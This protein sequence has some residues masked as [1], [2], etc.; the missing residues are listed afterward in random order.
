MIKNDIFKKLAAN[1][2]QTEPHLVRI[3]PT[4][5][6]YGEPVLRMP[7]SES[8]TVLVLVVKKL[9]DRKGEKRGPAVQ[10]LLTTTKGSFRV[11]Q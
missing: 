2:M 7:A 6:R 10:R 8:L 4:Q 5:R 1:L 3:K 9:Y 11:V